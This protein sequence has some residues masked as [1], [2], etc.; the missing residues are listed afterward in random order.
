[1][2]SAPVRD[3]LGDHLI[4]PQNATLV[5]IDYQ[6]SQFG[7]VRSMDPLACELQRDWNR[8]E[9]V[10]QIVEIALTERLLKE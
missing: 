7:T 6:P 1:M 8:V 3:Q 10:P 4:T 5:L 9:T 2:A